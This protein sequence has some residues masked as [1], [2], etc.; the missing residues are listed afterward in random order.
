M[1]WLFDVSRFCTHVSTQSAVRR[2][3]PKMD[4]QPDTMQAANDAHERR[5]KQLRRARTVR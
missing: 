1:Y 2:A 4:P 3:R 5:T